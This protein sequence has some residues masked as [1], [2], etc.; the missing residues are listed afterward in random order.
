MNVIERTRYILEQFPQIA[1]VCNVVHVDFADPEPTSYGLSSVDDTLIY[2]DILGGQL[3]QH[4]FLLYTTYS[5]INDYE[6]LHNASALLE[7]SQ[8]LRHQTGA[9]V[10]TDTGSGR[11]ERITAENG[12][13]YAV[14]QDN[15]EDAV[16]YQM[17]IIVRYTTGS[18]ESEGNT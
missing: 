17:R 3:R 8:W 12:M 14:P 13:L 2:E 10:I 6:R 18:E 4:S 15:I 7:L 5:G 11:I 9:E 16:Q 1:E